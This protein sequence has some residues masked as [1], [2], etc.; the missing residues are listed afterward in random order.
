MRKKV[1]SIVSALLIAAAMVQTATAAIRYVATDESG[2]WSTE[3]NR[4]ATFEAAYAA[5]EDGDEIWIAAG[6]HDV[7]AATNITKNISIYGGFAGTEATVDDRAKPAGGKPWEFANASTLRLTASIATGSG[8]FLINANSAGKSFIMEGVTLD[9]N[10]AGGITAKGI[11]WPAKATGTTSTVTISNV[12]IQ[13]FNSNHD[14]GGLNIRFSGFVMSNSL[15]TNNE[16]L[17]GAGGYIDQEVIVQDCWITNNKVNATEIT[18]YQG[19]Q[20]GAGGGLLLANSNTDS[21]QGVTVRNCYIAGNNAQFGGGVFV[22]NNAKIYNSIIVGNSSVISGSGVAF[23][24]RDAGGQVYNCIIAGNTSQMAGGAGVVFTNTGGQTLA[25]S[26]LYDNKDVNSAV[27]NIASASGASF[28]IKN[29]I[30]DNNSYSLGQ[31]ATVVNSTASELFADYASGDYTPP[32]TNFAG[33]DLGD[34]SGLTFADNKDYAGNTRIQGTAIEIGAYEVENP[35][36]P[37]TYTVGEGITDASVTA[38]QVMMTPGSY[39][40]TF[41]KESEYS[42]INVLVNDVWTEPTLDEETGTYTVNY[43]VS[44]AT[45]VTVSVSA[46]QFASNVI[47]VTEDTYVSNKSVDGNFFRSVSIGVA[48]DIN[49]A[50]TNTK[51]FMRFDLNPYKEA[52]LAA[53]YDKVELKVVYASANNKNFEEY[54]S[55]RTVKEEVKTVGLSALTWTNSGEVA[56]T[57]S[58]NEIAQS[59]RNLS[60]TPD[61]NSEDRID[62]S[63]NALE[64]LQGDGQLW[65][66]LALI[67]P[68]GNDKNDGHQL[69]MYSLENGNADYVPTLIFTKM[70]GIKDIQVEDDAVTDVKYYDLTGREIINPSAKGVYIIQKLHL[71]GK[72]TSSKVMLP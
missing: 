49:N 54:L 18:D 63:V 69:T 66:Q 64:A 17:K 5:A 4:Y 50:Y 26:I 71:S 28:V 53:G 23:E 33:L 30:L 34:A 35:E 8:M 16:A 46:Y 67:T 68:A 57:Y 6:T 60:G 70:T 36:V 13:N 52:L 21:G 24:K 62:L 39:S 58:G 11:N 51:A 9:G 48:G 22:R 25:N 10:K 55:V 45:P 31:T 29:N 7:A 65:Y 40:L 61:I 43:T 37:V 41:K 44:A 27:V 2:V 47:P 12:I 59:T 72:K 32:A 1:T 56:S 42:H 3:A 15:I 38:G 20:H 14:G 19:N